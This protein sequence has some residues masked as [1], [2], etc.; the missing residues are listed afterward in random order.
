MVNRLV[1]L[2]GMHVTGELFSGFMSRMPE[3]MQ[4]EPMHYPTDASPSYGQLL[5]AIRSFV[6]TSAPYILLA[7]SF[8][9]P[10]AIQ[11]AAT[12]PPNLRGLVLCVGFATSPLRGWRRSLAALIAPLAFRLPLPKVA[13]SHFLVGKDAPESLHASVRAAIRSVE[14]AV[15]AARAHQVFSV[16]ARLAL[17]RVSAPILFIQALQDRLVDE[18]SL[19]EM[20][21]I[22]PQIKVARIAGPHLILQR[23]PQQAAE[24]V[25]SFIQQL[26]PD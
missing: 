6:P 3:P 5:D 9:T 11:F 16:D 21:A 2:P 20:R 4:I 8:S 26:E 22:K 7:E 18:S 24:V 19:A 15:F 1:L 10:L 23:E 14:P 12:N 13:V 25:T 17:S